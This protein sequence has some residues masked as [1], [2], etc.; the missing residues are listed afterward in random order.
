MDGVSSRVIVTGLLKDSAEES[1]VSSEWGKTNMT[2]GLSTSG[3]EA[4]RIYVYSAIS[5]CG[6]WDLAASRDS[7]G[8]SKGRRQ[9]LYYFTYKPVQESR[10]CTYVVY[11]IR[12]C[13]V[14]IFELLKST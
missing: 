14:F 13:Y 7:K 10:F 3:V 9:Q 4:E 5:N 12:P 8:S 6:I 11:I 1:D 2:L